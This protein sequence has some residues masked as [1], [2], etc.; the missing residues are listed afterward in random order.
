VNIQDWQKRN[1]EAR[2]ED[3]KIL[4]ERLNGLDSNQS[5]LKE[6]LSM[7]PLLSYLRL[8]CNIS[9]AL[10]DAQHHSLEAM[11]ISLQK[12]L[13]ER[14]AGD[15]ELEFFS[16]SVRYLSAVSGYPTRRE[17]WMITSFEVEYGREIGSGG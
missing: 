17:S 10:L 15:R 2:L 11:M 6:M 3:Q 8:M 12:I 16:R 7:S 4:H 1:N 5:D 9:L 14:S 13:E